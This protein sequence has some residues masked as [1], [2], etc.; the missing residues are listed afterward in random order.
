MTLDMKNNRTLDD[1]YVYMA[2]YCKWVM[3][4]LKFKNTKEK[5]FICMYLH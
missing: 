4:F 3:K 5:H 2:L 1:K